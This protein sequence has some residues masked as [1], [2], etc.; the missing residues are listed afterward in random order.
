MCVGTKRCD[1]GV[2]GVEYGDGDVCCRWFIV[3]FV[4]LFSFRPIG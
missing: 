4:V 3:G 1:Y 2:G